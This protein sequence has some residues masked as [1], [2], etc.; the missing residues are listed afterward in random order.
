MNKKYSV[1]LEISDL[2]ETISK[3]FLGSTLAMKKK[4]ENGVKEGN[5]LQ[6]PGKMMGKMWTKKK[7]DKFSYKINITVDKVKEKQMVEIDDEDL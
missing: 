4:Y 7:N 3:S 6:I 2:D 1:K 5:V